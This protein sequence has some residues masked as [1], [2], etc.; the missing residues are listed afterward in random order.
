MA[1]ATSE[2]KVSSVKEILAEDFA[3][4]ENYY[5]LFGEYQEVLEN[6]DPLT[7]PRTRFPRRRSTVA[8]R[9]GAIRS[10]W[11]HLAERLPWRSTWARNGQEPWQL[12]Q[13]EVRWPELEQAN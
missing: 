7:S 3:H 9:I 2:V 6:L 5:T 11:G 10:G 1:R 13:D 12:L 4:D 8:R